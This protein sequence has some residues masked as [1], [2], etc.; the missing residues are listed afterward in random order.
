[1]KIYYNPTTESSI[2]GI[3]KESRFGKQ[4]YDIGKKHPPQSPLNR[5]AGSGSPFEMS[6]IRLSTEG[7]GDVFLKPIKTISQIENIFL[8]FDT[9]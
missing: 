8:T 2:K 7:Y 6:K 1:M 4:S 3:K 5:G 9:T